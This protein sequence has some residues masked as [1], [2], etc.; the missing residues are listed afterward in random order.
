VIDVTVL[1]ALKS[2]DIHHVALRCAGFNNIALQ[3]ARKLGISVSRVPSYSAESV[4]EHTVGIIL[5]LN[6]KLFKAS[7]RVLDNNSELDGLL[8]FNLRSKTVGVVGTGSIGR[9]LVEIL[10]G[11]GCHILCCDPSPSAK[12]VAM[13]H[14]YVSLEQ[15]IKESDVIS[16]HCPINADSPCF[17][18]K[19]ER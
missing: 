10:T 18:T 2:F 1:K 14:E 15:L 8:G 7:N 12:I 5:A 6:R 17:D 3:Q 9:R 13:G 11:F 4:A 19:Y 16:L